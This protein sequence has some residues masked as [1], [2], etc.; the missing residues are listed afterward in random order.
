[1]QTSPFTFARCA[2]LPSCYSTIIIFQLNRF[3]SC[4][5]S[6]LFRLLRCLLAMPLAA[7]HLSCAAAAPAAAPAPLLSD[8]SHSAWGA[9]QGAPVDVLKF[10]QGKDGWLW[11]ATATGLYRYDGVHFERTDSVY[12]HRLPSSNVLGLAIAPDGAIWIGYR[13]GGVTVF[14]PDGARNYGAAE[15]L[16][17]GAVLHIERS[18]DGAIWVGTRDGAARLAPGAERFEI[19]GDNVGLPT[20]RVY[21]VLFGRD[22]T[23]WMGT[24]YG[25][26]FRRPGQARFSHA[27]PRTMLTSMAEAPDGAIWAVDNDNH[28]YRVRTSEPPGKRPLQPD[29]IGNGMRFDRAGTMWLFSA[30]GVERKFVPRGPILPA[31][32]LTRQ[33]GIS[34]PLPQSSFQ[35]REGNLWFGTSAGLDR[36][37]PNR[38]KTLPVAEPFDHPGMLPGPDGDVW[39]GDYAGD[40]R[41]FTANGVK[42]V[43]LKGHLAASHWAPDGTLWLGNEL[44]LHQRAVNGVF[45]PVALPPGV[46]G[47]DPQALQQDRAGDLWASFSGG[48][49]FRRTRGTWVRDGGLSGL[50]TVLTT[51]MAM[52]GQGTVWLG[53]ADNSISL[54]GQSQH[55]G[56][57]RRLGASDGLQLGAVLQ[58]YRDGDAMWAGG[59]HGVALYRAGRFH[60]LRGSQDETFRGVSGMLR[61]PDGD[62]W[63]HGADAIYHITASSLAAWLADTAG[64]VEFERFDALDGLQGHATQLR[65]IPSLIRAP[66]GKLWFATAATIAMLDPAHIARNRLPPPVQIHTLLADGKPW[67]TRPGQPLRLP[68]GSKNLQIGFT[69]LSLSMPERVR[70]RYRLGSVDAGWQEAVGRREAY[71]TNLAPGS[72][73]FE[74]LA[75]NE[76]GVW[77]QQG[78]QLEIVIAP[79]F[80]QTPWFKLLLAL[81]GALLL[82]GGYVLRIRHLKRSMHARLQERL[83]ERLAERSRI[84][85]SLHDT[86]LQ[87]VQGLILS[88]HAHAHMLPQGTR[89]RARLDGTLNLADQLLIEG[90]DQIMDLRAVA[91]PDELRLALQQFGKG[92]AE[93]RAHAFE[94]RVS[95]VCRRLQ[96][97]VHDE[98]YA[99][100][101]EALFNA[102]RYAEAAHIVLELDYAEKAFVL[103]V[104]DDGCGLDDAVAQAGRPGH[105]GLV[106]MRERAASIGASLSITSRAGAGTQIE[107]SVPGHLAY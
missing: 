57:V 31:Q 27:W 105:W 68:Q 92:L 4:I 13:L 1:M 29:A 10:A 41:S 107:V 64:P 50:P 104:R 100:A 40:I 46:A 42:K 14:R 23:Q 51:A 60:T 8:Y 102:S 71:Y 54:V 89:E 80:V 38:L 53:H 19:Q 58:L 6:M 30:D 86:L 96:P 11:I 88:F 25:V 74:V 18:P 97:C 28:Y 45:T 83:Q 32:R 106:G 90:R 59:E 49:L 94:V 35:D 21:Q 56:A 93:H 87:S 48:G 75:A 22:G 91:P 26:F 63:L 37:R 43:E 72:Y 103:R 65:P 76:D 7:L 77:N 34:G 15:G 17:T 47:L 99:I 24:M 81:G 82:Y 69:A 20:R 73:R 36:L 98:I 55:D 62:L 61:L 67:P 78:A 101:R 70:L 12:G 3:H 95:G 9:V 2:R 16:P 39:I 66:D 85:R 84:A 52:D 44:G 5:H 79:T 33:N